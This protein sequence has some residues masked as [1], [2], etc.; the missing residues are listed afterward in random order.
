[1]STRKIV[2]EFFGLSESDFSDKEALDSKGVSF[3][4]LPK[5]LRV[6]KEDFNSLFKTVVITETEEQEIEA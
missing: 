5:K 3:K 1:M 2:A 6:T 4:A